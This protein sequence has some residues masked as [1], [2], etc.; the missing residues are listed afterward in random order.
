MNAM[1]VTEVSTRWVAYGKVGLC[2]N[3]N[4]EGILMVLIFL[5]LSNDIVKRG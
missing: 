2:L 4:L 5:E 3:L 1:M